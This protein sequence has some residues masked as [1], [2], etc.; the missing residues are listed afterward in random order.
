MGLMTTD[1]IRDRF[2]KFFE[3][4][5]H[6]I[7]SSDSLIPQNDP[8][9]LFSGAGMNQ[10]KDYFLGL[11]K[12]MKRA[13]SSQ[14]CLRTGDLD[15]VG[16]TPY[17]H[18]FFEMLG[19]FSFGDYFKKE[20]IQWAWEFLTDEMNISKERLRVSVHEKDEE[21]YAIWKD[22]IK[23]RPEWIVKLG[24]KGNFWPSNAPKDGPNGPCGPCSE[25]YFDQGEQV[26]CGKKHCN[27]DC[28]CG[29]FAEIWNL[30]FTQ[31]DR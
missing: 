9:L 16:K 15:N 11:K 28:D 8:T 7:V 6:K 31:F 12:D 3:G 13:A 2:L 17:H 1:E 14:K 4:K 21:A 26:G 25:I 20:A 29:R 30:V 19:N 5:A 27:I 23:L 24:D 10:F 18:S 22:A